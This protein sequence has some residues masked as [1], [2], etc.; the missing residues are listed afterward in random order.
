M[1]DKIQNESPGESL[2][3]T[4]SD[5]ETLKD[6]GKFDPDQGVISCKLFYTKPIGITPANIFVVFFLS[7]AY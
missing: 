3:L 2:L 6:K 4:Q 7:F 5:N 1:T